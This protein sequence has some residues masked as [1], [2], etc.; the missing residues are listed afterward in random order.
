[1]KSI[2]V[3]SSRIAL[4]IWAAVVFQVALV[5]SIARADDGADILANNGPTISDLVTGDGAR[6]EEGMKPD[7]DVFNATPI[8]D[9]NTGGASTD[10]KPCPGVR[11]TRS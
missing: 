7:D 11:R 9:I 5:C 8:P 2:Y 1:M 4:G 10:K 3:D 6:T